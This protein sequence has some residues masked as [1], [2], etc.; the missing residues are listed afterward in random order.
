MNILF[1]NWHCFL[2]ED[3][4][5]TL[6]DLGHTV[7][8]FIH[9]DFR[10]RKSEA[11]HSA[12]LKH[13]EDNHTELAFSYNYYPV[14]AEAC[15]EL[16]IPYIS[17]LYDSPY[18][19][20][21]S[22][23]LAYPT[24]YVFLFDSD[25]ANYFIQG[26]LP[27]VYYHT[28]P[29]D[30]KMLPKAKKHPLNRSRLSS[31]LSFVGSLYHED[32]TFY[33]RLPLKKYPYMKGYFEGIMEAQSKVYGYNFIQELLTPEIMEILLKEYPLDFSSDSVSPPEYPYATYF[34]D[35]KLTSIE[36][37]R[38][39]TAIGE[40]FGKDYSLKLFTR[41]QGVSI[42]GVKNMGTASYEE[43]M[44]YVYENSKIN[45]NISLRS[46]TSGIPMRCMDI[47]SCG[48]FLLTNYQGDFAP[49][50]IPG[51]DYDFFENTEDLLG[52]IDYYLS[53]EKER[54]EIAENGAQKAMEL[55]SLPKVM[56][57]LIGIACGG[58]N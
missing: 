22:Y 34:L 15:K 30:P 16:D 44:P 32:H 29:A 36:R 40:R 48:G 26:G 39:I 43:E 33:D 55:Y 31:D 8:L 18:Q 58:K 35:R 5:S 42:P 45:L 52:K 9:D 12:F 4:I 51:E 50:F 6:Q 10:E 57:E 53:H 38:Y 47:F 17:F 49:D 46:I 3:T 23:T 2:G 25:L 7:S 27:N 19:M 14:M 21:F 37:K 28:L 54:R 11:F 41:D 56:E 1:L 13:A 20:I 24:N